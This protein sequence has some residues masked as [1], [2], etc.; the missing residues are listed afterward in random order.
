M[1][2]T[3]FSGYRDVKIAISS[4]AGSNP[5]DVYTNI[6]VPFDD[7]TG[8]YKKDAHTYFGEDINTLVQTALK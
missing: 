1:Y 5:I 3:Y 4:T 8:S 7:A 2:R 6:G